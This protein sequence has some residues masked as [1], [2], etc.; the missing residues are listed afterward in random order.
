MNK[1]KTIFFRFSL[2]IV[3]IVFALSSC[4]SLFTIDKGN[5]ESNPGGRVI[6][7]NAIGSSATNDSFKWFFD[8]EELTDIFYFEFK[9]SF[10]KGSGALDSLRLLDSAMLNM[11]NRINLNNILLTIDDGN[12][13]TI[14]GYPVSEQNHTFRFPVSRDIINQLLN[15]KRFTLQ[16]ISQ[17]IHVAHQRPHSVTQGTL[18]YEGVKRFINY[19]NSGESP[20]NIASVNTETQRVTTQPSASQPSAIQTR[21]SQ[22]N[23][24]QLGENQTSSE[25]QT[26]EAQSRVQYDG[27]RKLR[28]PSHPRNCCHNVVRRR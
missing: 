1:K 14:N 28:Y 10:G 6:I 13:I 12:T 11:T 17:D 3:V 5:T 7:T 4:G 26:S 20:V 16:P 22:T 18:P 24:T 8:R 27:D 9:Y 21:E 19:W 25:T 15:C 2:F 23:V